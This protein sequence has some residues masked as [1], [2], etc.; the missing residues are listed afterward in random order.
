MTAHLQLPY[1]LRPVCTSNGIPRGELYVIL[2]L[3]F[4]VGTF[5]CITLTGNVTYK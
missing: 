5:Y 1:I 4:V 2:Q 3:L